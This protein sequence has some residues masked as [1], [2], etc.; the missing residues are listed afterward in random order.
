M[1]GTISTMDDGLR[2]IDRCRPNAYGAETTTIFQATLGESGKTPE[3]STE[4]MRAA[5]NDNAAFILDTRS[6]ANSTPAMFQAPAISAPTRRP[7]RRGRIADRR[8]QGRSADPLLQRPLLP[9][10]PPA[11]RAIVA[12]RLQQCA[13]LPARDPGLAGARRTCRDR[14]CRR[15]A[16]LQGGPDRRLYR[17]PPGRGLRRR[18][19][20]RRDQCARRGCRFRQVEENRAAGRRFQ[21]AHHPVRRRSRSGPQACRLHG[22]APLAQRVVFSGTLRRAGRGAQITSSV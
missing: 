13:A 14:A 4:Q 2:R 12:R 8:Q 22:Q 17:R 9:G 11:R 7:R 5:L 20:A 19:P 21:P 3:I 10:E 18:K 6:R 1:I 16:R 15:V